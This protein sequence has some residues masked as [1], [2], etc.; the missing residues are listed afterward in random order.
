MGRLAFAIAIG[1]A[2][3]PGAIPAQEDSQEWLEECRDRYGDD[4]RDTYCEVKEQRLPA[5]SG[6]LDVDGRQ[7]GGISVRGWDQ[8]EILVRA[9]IRTWAR[10]EERAREL[11]SEIQIQSA[12]GR[13]RAAGPTTERRTSWSVSYEIFVPRSYNLSLDT[14]NGGI[15]VRDVRGRMDLSAHNGGL[16]LENVGG[17]VRGSTTNGGLHVELDGDKWQGEGLDLRTTNGGVNMSIP[18]NY[19]AT[20][21]TGTVNG[22]MSIDFPITVQGRITRRLTTQLGNGG[23]TIRAV[24]TNGGVKIRRG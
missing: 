16:H 4:D 14:Y 23:P 17:D 22:G 5:S 11:A 9:R 24:T 10:S 21:E 18:S 12:D 3:A 1:V 6:T 20:L 15:R 7:N 2:V 19:S 8:R 13:V